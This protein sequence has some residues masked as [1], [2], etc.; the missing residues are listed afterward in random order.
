M[1]RLVAVVGALLIASPTTAQQQESVHV[2]REGDTLWELARTYLGDPFLWPEIFRLNT[3]VVADP[4]RIH[5]A[6]R[7]RIPVGIRRAAGAPLMQQAGGA[8]TQPV[9][10]GD[11]YRA[12]VLVDDAEIRPI[13]QLAELESPSVVPIAV[14]QQIAPFDRVFVALAGPNLARTGD[15]LHLVRRE[16]EIRPF[17]R[18]FRSTGIATVVAVEGSIATVVISRM[19]DKV[20]TGD[21]A[22][23]IE[24]IPGVGGNASGAQ[25]GA[26][27]KGRI[28]A[29]QSPHPVQMTQEIAFIDVGAESGVQT[30]DEL[31]AY[32]PREQ[33]T[34]GT[35]PE[36]NV[37]RLQVVRV[38]NQT[39]SVRITGLDQP[40]LKAGLPVR[41]VAASP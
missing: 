38:T 5:P 17:G 25:R 30:G 21:L 29:F 36:I 40:A 22:V 8:D 35:R 24:R 23:P 13:G 19:Y 37:A 20:A 9:V 15:R 28:V 4:A 12:A 6:T 41:R 32:L 14:G 7:L 33:R 3:D 11:F 10:S 31:V 2:V 16:R 34:W 27:V 18:V 39:A 26:P 1:R